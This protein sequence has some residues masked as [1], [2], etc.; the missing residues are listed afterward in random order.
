MFDLHSS[1]SSLSVE[2]SYV[3]VR[4]CF[5]ALFIFI[6]QCGKLVCTYMFPGIVQ[7]HHS[8]WKT[9][10]Y[11]SVSEY[12]SY[13]SLSVENSYVHKCFRVLFIFITQ[14]GKRVCTYMFPGI[15]HIYHSVWKTRMCIRVY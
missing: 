10:M 14:C 7:I 6:T 1:Y 11:I 13:S 5:L 8:V 2:T 15:V 12:C 3:H 9:C 4:S